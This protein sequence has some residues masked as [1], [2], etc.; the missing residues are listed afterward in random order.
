MFI[1]EIYECAQGEGRLVGVPSILVRTSLC[2]LRCQFS[3]GNLCDTWFTSWKPETNNNMSV[4]AILDKVDALAGTTY[5]HVILSG[6]EPTIQKE[7][8]ELVAKLSCKYHVTIESNGTNLVDMS[9]Q[10]YEYDTRNILFSI[11][12]KLKSSVPFGT[13][14]EKLHDSKRINLKSLESLLGVYDSYLKFVVC[15]PEDLTEVL[16]IQQQLRVDS[17]RIYLMPEGI[18]KEQVESKHSMIM[19]L[20]QKYG[21]RFSTRLHIL[22]YGNKRKT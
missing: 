15:T 3:G 17:D 20:C 13:P 11:S 9:Q 10:P 4:Q 14:F 7:F 21:F 2:N 8:A 1:S 5:K 16:S 6:G 22:L 19:D 12:P 18:T